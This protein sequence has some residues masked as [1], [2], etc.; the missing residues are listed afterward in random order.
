MKRRDSLGVGVRG[1]R[2]GFRELEGRSCEPPEITVVGR[3]WGS[4]EVTEM[5]AIDDNGF[6]LDTGPSHLQ[7]GWMGVCV[8]TCVKKI[9]THGSAQCSRK[10]GALVS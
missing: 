2:E 3:V 10:H 5:V 7:T 4:V 9:K 1:Q 8:G 6:I